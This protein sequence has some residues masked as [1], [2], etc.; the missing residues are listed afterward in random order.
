MAAA[1]DVID[2]FPPRARLPSLWMK[3]RSSVAFGSATTK[4]SVFAM[5]NWDS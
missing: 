4:A 5:S 2:H 1:E 3:R